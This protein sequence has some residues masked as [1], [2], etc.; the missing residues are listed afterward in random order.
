MKTSIHIS[1]NRISL[2]AGVT[3]AA[4][5]ATMKN[6]EHPFPFFKKRSN[7]IDTL[8]IKINNQN[9]ETTLLENIEN[10]AVKTLEEDYLRLKLKL[11][12]S[13]VT[14]AAAS[15][16]A[17]VA[18]QKIAKKAGAGVFSNLIGLAAGAGTGAALFSQMKPDLR[19]WHT[20]PANLQMSRIFL[21]PGI[22]HITFEGLDSR[23]RVVKRF[24]EKISIIKGKINFFNVRTLF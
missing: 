4:I 18:A 10:T 24:T 7:K 3:M 16:G 21:K 12:G 19:C 1:L 2:G 17:G 5:L 11:A 23:K 20:L 8:R 9:Y 14:K 6:A 13:I 22:Y 15:V